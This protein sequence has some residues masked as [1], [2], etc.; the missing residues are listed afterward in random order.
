M[1]NQTET[2]IGSIDFSKGHVQDGPVASTIPMGAL[3]VKLLACIGKLP[4]VTKVVHRRDA[5]R[6]GRDVG[7]YLRGLVDRLMVQSHQ[8]FGV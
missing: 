5:K 7:K 2:A 6:A 1:G 4:G 3:N 8:L